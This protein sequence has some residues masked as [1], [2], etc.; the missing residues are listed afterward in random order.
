MDKLQILLQVFF[1]LS[2][3]TTLI[4]QSRRFYTLTHTGNG[5]GYALVLATCLEGKVTQSHISLGLHQSLD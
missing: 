3:V 5:K 4:Q 1:R 2:W